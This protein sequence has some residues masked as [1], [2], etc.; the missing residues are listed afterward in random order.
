MRFCVKDGEIKNLPVNGN[1]VVI[2]Q[3]EDLK[4]LGNFQC[5]D[6][7]YFAN[8]ENKWFLDPDGKWMPASGNKPTEGALTIQPMKGTDVVFEHTVSDLQTGVFVG[9]AKIEGTLSYVST[10]ALPDLWGA[11]HFLALQFGGT[12][13]ERAEHIWVGLDPTQG[14]GLADVIHDDERAGV[15]KITNTLQRFKAIVDY[16]NYTEAYDLDLSGLTLAAE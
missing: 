5:G 16:G 7:A 3:A 6:M 2:G 9:T 11:G 8:C 13:F 1:K 4:K 10:G 14:S 12:A 15:F